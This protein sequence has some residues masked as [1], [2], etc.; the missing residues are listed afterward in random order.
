M[1]PWEENRKSCR[2]A[3]CRSGN[4]LPV[5]SRKVT[6]RCPPGA[7]VYAIT[8]GNFK[9]Q[10]DSGRPNSAFGR[11]STACPVTRITS[12][13]I[14][15]HRPL[16]IPRRKIPPTTAQIGGRRRSHTYPVGS[17]RRTHVHGR[18]TGILVPVCNLAPE[19]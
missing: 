16:A 19:G 13:R 7:I 6:P 8:L 12:T 17:G 10:V 4:S 18:K 9:I 11:V 3:A 2:Y 15:N 5:Q 1:R 14:H